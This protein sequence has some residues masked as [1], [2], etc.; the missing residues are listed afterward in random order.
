MDHNLDSPDWGDS[1]DIESVQGIT[2]K[3]P[4]KCNQCEYASSKASNL[5]RHLEMHSGEKQN[6]CN[7]C[8]FASSQAGNLRTHLKH[9]VEKSQTNATNATFHPF[10]QA[11]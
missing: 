2:S 9:T 10:R 3:R 11:I 7:Q 5:R 1:V 6:K 4:N 8:D